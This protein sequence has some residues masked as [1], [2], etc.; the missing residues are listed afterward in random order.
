MK[1]SIQKK[2][3]EKKGK[4]PKG[5]IKQEDP[6]GEIKQE[7]PKEEIKT[8]ESLG[9]GK[10]KREDEDDVTFS[11]LREA[12]RK[13]H[14]KPQSVVNTIH[15]TECMTTGDHRTSECIKTMCYH[16][17][18]FGHWANQCPEQPS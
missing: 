1:S 5:E 2:S 13:R 7:D 12:I 6:K 18:Q 3:P 10:R 17:K 11:I 9:Q 8:D 14:R 16:C 4:D 15:C